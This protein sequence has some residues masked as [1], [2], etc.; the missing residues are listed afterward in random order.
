VRHDSARIA[1]L[2]RDLEEMDK[3]A[4]YNDCAIKKAEAIL[5]R[6]PGTYWLGPD[7]IRQIV[8]AVREIGAGEV[9]YGVRRLEDLLE[10][11][12]PDWREWL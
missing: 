9:A 8:L 1:K 10:E 6:Q 5:G 4:N 3:L 11:T 7:G 12:R 2:E